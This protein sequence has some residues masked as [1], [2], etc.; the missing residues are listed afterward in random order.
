MSDFCQTGS[1]DIVTQFD[2][3]LQLFLM[4]LKFQCWS[5]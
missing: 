1:T 3:L 4:N 5:F 2:E